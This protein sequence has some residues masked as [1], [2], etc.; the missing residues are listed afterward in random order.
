MLGKLVII[1]IKVPICLL[2]RTS[3]NYPRITLKVLI[4]HPRAFL[5]P[6]FTTD[7]HV[8]Q[9]SIVRA[10]LHPSLGEFLG[11]LARQA[12]AHEPDRLSSLINPLVHRN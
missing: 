4:P 11:V 2:E 5:I 12:A 10:Y 7:L 8:K 9:D 1:C 3:P 6:V